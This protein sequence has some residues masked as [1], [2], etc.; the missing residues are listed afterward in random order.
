MPS[1]HKNIQF[2]LEFFKIPFLVLHFSYYALTIL[3]MMLSLILLSIRSVI[4]HLICGNNSN[5]LLNLNLIY[6]TLWEW[7]KKWIAGF[8]ARKTQLLS[9]DWSYNTGAI[10]VKM[11]ESALEEK[12]S[13]KM[14]GLIFSSKLD[15]D[16]YIIFIVKTSSKKIGALIHSFI[17]LSLLCIS[18]NLPYAHVWNIVVTSGLV[19][20]VATWIC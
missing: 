18:I 9:F 17:L 7:G 19:P 13:F 14:L 1:L 2:M 3:L 5:G 20:P 8:N 12:S 15:W 6:E 4:R 10:D 11:N 16:S